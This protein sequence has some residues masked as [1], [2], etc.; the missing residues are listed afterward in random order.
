MRARAIRLE[1]PR[2]TPSAGTA[3]AVA[4]AAALAMGAAA[5]ADDALPATS[6]AASSQI[7]FPT[8]G[9]SQ[10][11]PPP[12]TVVNETPRTIDLLGGALAGATLE[13][14]LVLLDNLG[15]CKSARGLQ[16]LTPYFTDG[17]PWLRAAATRAAGMI[18]DPSVVSQVASL[19]NDPSAEVRTAAIEA[20]GALHAEAVITAGL[21]DLDPGVVAAAIRVAFTS[22]QADLIAGKLSALPSETAPLAIAAL[23]RLNANGDATQIVSMMSKSLAC[24]VAALQ[25]LGA[26]KATSQLPV[27]QENL[28]DSNPAVRAA[29]VAALSGVAGADMQATLAA[30]MVN[31]PDQSDGPDPSVQYQ[32]ALLL[33]H[34]PNVTARDTLAGLLGSDYPGMHDAALSALAALG[35]DAAPAAN[36]LMEDKSAPRRVDGVTLAGLINETSAANKAIAL[37]N[38]PDATVDVAAAKTLGVIGDAQAFTPLENFFQRAAASEKSSEELYSSGRENALVSAAELHDVNLLASAR[39]LALQSPA[40]PPN[41]DYPMVREA[42]AFAVGMLAPQ[43]DP[44]CGA[45]TRKLNDTSQPEA[46]ATLA[47]DYKALVN[48]HDAATINGMADFVSDETKPFS[49]RWYARQAMIKLGQ[50]APALPPAT[51]PFEPQLMI[52]DLPQ[53]K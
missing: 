16:Y 40:P 17:N 22:A 30:K 32:S 10:D 47:E 12:V 6:P 15:Q 42:A 46:D 53:P 51:T 19:M 50:P 49:Q 14:K 29:A 43:Q 9:M 11:I 7:I 31:D 1:F 13:N 27:V 2:I 28:S 18:G 25:A 23:G 34:A 52:S 24:R 4:C 37:L 39:N 21:T 36:A 26:I 38:D 35:P 45:L 33:A 3:L 44:I 8:Y 48:L 41:P 5:F 20:A